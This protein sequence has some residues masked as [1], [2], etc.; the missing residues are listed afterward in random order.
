[1]LSVNTNTQPRTRRLIH[2][3]IDERGR[4]DDTRLLHLEI[5]IVAFARPLAHTTEDRLS[6]VPL[7]DIVDQLHDDD[8]LSDA[9][10]AKESD[11]STLHERSDKIDDL[12]SSLEDFSLGLEVRE[13]RRGTVD[14]PPLHAVRNRR[15]VVDRVAE[16]VEN[17]S[18]RGLANRNRDRTA[19]V[20]D[21]H[22]ADDGVGRRHCHRAHLIASDVLLHLDDDINVGAGIGLLTDA[23]SVVKLGQVLGLEL[24]VQHRSD[25]LDYPA[26][27]RLLRLC[28]CR[29]FSL[30]A[31]G[32]SHDYPCNAEA[33]P[34][35]SAISCVICAWRARLKVRRRTLSISPALLVAFFIAVR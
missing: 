32:R 17:S 13:L 9:G 18:E 7:R 2:L 16:H 5:K 30:R 15:T 19:G 25:N 27:I 34:T 23:Q 3:A 14:R 1:M 20:F 4:I 22:P 24:D 21:L 33:P 8:G 6:A 29:L 10:A 26:E 31:D 12:D 28:R 35:I 11:L